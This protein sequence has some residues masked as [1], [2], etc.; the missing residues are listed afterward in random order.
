MKD[1]DMD[2]ANDTELMGDTDNNSKPIILYGVDA[3]MKKMGLD[4]R[5]RL[6]ILDAAADLDNLS[7]RLVGQVQW[8]D[9]PRKFKSFVHCASQ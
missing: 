7:S 2:D 5:P 6:L 9:G 4:V 3:I 8:L 1:I